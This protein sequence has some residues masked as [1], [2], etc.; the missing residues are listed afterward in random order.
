MSKMHC[1]HC[2]SLMQ[3]RIV[4][5]RTRDV[6][7]TCQ[8]VAYRNPVPAV[9]TIVT[10]DG[11]IVLVKRKFGPRAGYW[12]LP[13]GYMECGESTEDA[14]VRECHEETHLLVQTDELVGV[15]SYSSGA[16]SGLL[17]VYAATAVGGHLEADDDAA[18]VD[19]FA[20]DAL[21]HPLAF[22]IHAQAIGDWQRTHARASATPLPLLET[23]DGITVRLAHPS[24]EDQVLRLL[25]L[26]P[27]IQ[28]HVAD[29]QLLTSALFRHRLKEADTPILVA[30]SNR[31]VV[32]LAAL[33]FRRTLTGWRAAIDDMVVA[34]VYRR[35]GL[36]QNL[37]QAAVRLARSR[38]CDVLHM[39]ATYDP[40]GARSFF[41]ACGFAEGN[42]ASLRI[43]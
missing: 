10:L 26:L 21:P 29:Q 42:V 7:L 41:L 22:R 40:T 4:E 43:N 19:T 27:S 8:H 20:L 12:C 16:A 28:T 5:G 25:S 30:E 1:P 17:V 34:P 39:D 35:Q 32:G 15:Y 36:G 9:G 31:T 6:C 38:D 23:D 13:A 2:G 3:Q 24:D 33:S 37:V 18:A 14:A 11:R